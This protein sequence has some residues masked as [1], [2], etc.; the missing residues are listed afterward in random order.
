MGLCYSN[1]KPLN[2][3]MYQSIHTHNLYI[4]VCLI[5][6]IDYETQRGCFNKD[7]IPEI[8]II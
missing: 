6:W 2:L 8:Q 4:C 7:K 1:Y 5:G 3:S